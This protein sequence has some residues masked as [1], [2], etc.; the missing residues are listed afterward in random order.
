LIKTDRRDAKA[1][2]EL[3]WINR[4]R[5]LRGDQ[6][7]LSGQPGCSAVGDDAGG[8]HVHGLGDGLPNRSGG[9]VSAESEPRE[10]PGTDA[11]LPAVRAR[12]S[13]W[14][15]APRWAAGWCVAFRDVAGRLPG[16]Q[17]SQLLLAQ[18]AGA[19]RDVSNV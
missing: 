4:E 9:A 12:A 6:S 1:L 2:S 3:L 8:E 16:S 11:G 15:R 13:D 5:L 18:Q 17:D 14:G 19:M 10:F 7:A